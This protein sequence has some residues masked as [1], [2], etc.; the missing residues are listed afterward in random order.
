MHGEATMET[1]STCKS[2][3]DVIILLDI[4]TILHHHQLKVV[5]LDINVTT[6][7]PKL[8]LLEPLITERTVA[9]LVAHIYG[10]WVTM[11]PI[12]NIAEKYGIKVIE[13]CAEGFHGF[14]MLGHPKTDIS[15]FSFG[16]IKTQTAFGGSVAKVKDHRVHHQMLERY[17]SCPIQTHRQYL[18]KLLKCSLIYVFMRHQL[19]TKCG[20][21]LLRSLGLDHKPFTVKLMRGFPDQLIQRI[22]TQPSDAL[23]NMLQKR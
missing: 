17:K 7:E 23:V 2:F 8:D 22:R 10:K 16:T 18:H 15:L 5:A 3:K 20:M 14:E 19:I 6:T 1:I 11:E 12:V 4:A 21:Y 9:I 13:D